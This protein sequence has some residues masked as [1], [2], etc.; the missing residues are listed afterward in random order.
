M[1]HPEL[2][3]SPPPEAA[4][5]A[6]RRAGADL[7]FVRER[8]DE[9]PDVRAWLDALEAGLPDAGRAG[10]VWRPAGAPLD[11]GLGVAHALHVDRLGAL[12]QALSDAQEH[13]TSV[14]SDG[15]PA[16]MPAFVGG[17]AFQTGAPL[18]T[19]W[20]PFGSGAWILPAMRL[21][22]AED[23]SATITRAWHR[24]GEA[25]RPAS[26][27]ADC[28]DAPPQPSLDDGEDQPTFE[29]RVR[30]AASAIRAGNLRKVV[31]ARSRVIRRERTPLAVL[32]LGLGSRYPDCTLFAFAPGDGSV[33][34]G[35]TPE[36]LLHAS[37]GAVR[38]MALAGSAP[39]GATASEDDLHARRLIEDPKERQEHALVVED[40]LATARKCGVVL[41]PAS[42][43]DV[44]RLHNVQ[45]LHTPFSGTL[46]APEDALALA[47]ALHP[48]P[49]V[50]GLPRTTALDWLRR[51]ERGA[52]G[53]YAGPFGAVQSPANVHLVVA[54]RSALFRGDQAA[55]F[56]GAGILGA[57]DP[58]REYRETRAKMDALRDLLTPA[59]DAP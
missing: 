22:V 10:F 41:I 4:R 29:T 26:L 51:T 48:T 36:T 33:F 38:T 9:T 15:A 50:G 46:D 17:C 20:R 19:C 37:D 30:E 24:D 16:P 23:G 2:H 31:L 52:R 5:D 13:M 44:L 1:P 21:Q 43:P 28:I 11:I 8:L 27:S 59:P 14:H 47:T 35:I 53:W 12:G 49:A 34:A 58:T 3:R 25:W 18:P 56:A 55:L 39:R 7:L 57:S 42:E 54:L 6:S 40:I 32:L 45:H